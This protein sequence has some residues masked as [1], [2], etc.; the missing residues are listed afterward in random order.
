MTKYTVEQDAI[1]KL[2]ALV[3]A[4][5]EETTD[6][7]IKYVLNQIFSKIGAEYQQDSQ[8]PLAVEIFTP[9]ELTKTFRTAIRLFKGLQSQR[10]ALLVF[11]DDDKRKA[12]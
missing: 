3:I 10:K 5:H 11:D 4:I 6:E 8:N 2:A 9:G 12:Q 1:N 7:A